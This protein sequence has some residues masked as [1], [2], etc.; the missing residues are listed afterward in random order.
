MTPLGLASQRN[1][2]ST[3]IYQLLCDEKRLVSA[4][5]V[6]S[7]AV[8]TQAFPHSW[9]P[10]SY[11]RRLPVSFASDY[12]HTV[13]MRVVRTPSPVYRVAFDTPHP[14][15]HIPLPS[16]PVSTLRNIHTRSG[17]GMVSWRKVDKRY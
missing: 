14:N 12:R 5:K 10:R 7:D 9:F 1:N 6:S 4:V 16:A 8:E 15:S 3:V 17:I 2:N 13:M 11:T